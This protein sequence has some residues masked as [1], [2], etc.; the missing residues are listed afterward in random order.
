MTL[1]KEIN[2]NNFESNIKCHFFVDD[3]ER[4]LIIN[5]KGVI[6]LGSEGSIDVN[7]IFINTVG[8]YFFIEPIALLFDLRDLEYKYGNSINKILNF[9]QI[10]GRDDYEKKLPIYF[11]ISS[12][13]EEGIANFLGCDKNA[14]PTHF[15]Y[16][17]DD[18]K[19]VLEHIK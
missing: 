17:L 10:V 16:N 1:Y 2:H 5:T 14:L 19:K 13:N 4:I 9:L 6:R 8:Y 3:N 7:K 11:V 15:F 12:K 18:A